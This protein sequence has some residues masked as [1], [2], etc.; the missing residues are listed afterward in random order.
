MKLQ[1]DSIRPWYKQNMKHPSMIF[2]NMS[3]NNINRLDRDEMDSR[4]GSYIQVLSFFK[5]LEATYNL[6][7]NHLLYVCNNQLLFIALSLP[8]KN[9]Y[10]CREH[11]FAFRFFVPIIWKLCLNFHS[12]WKLLF[13]SDCIVFDCIFMHGK[14][15]RWPAAVRPTRYMCVYIGLCEHLNL[16]WLP[17]ISQNNANRY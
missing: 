1:C 5:D 2:L 13:T 4:I 17:Q 9:L 14:H 7:S 10:L 8:I 3:R 6:Y 16:I 11:C 15:S 12:W